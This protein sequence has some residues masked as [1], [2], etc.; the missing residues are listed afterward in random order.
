MARRQ[1]RGGGQTARCVIR[2]ADGTSPIGRPGGGL[3]FMKSVSP[4]TPT[5]ITIHKRITSNAGSHSNTV[6]LETNQI[7]SICLVSTHHIIVSHTWVCCEGYRGISGSSCECDWDRSGLLRY[8]GEYKHCRYGSSGDSDN[9]N[10]A[11]TR[12][13]GYGRIG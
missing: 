5:F 2:A 4:S 8:T 13:C 11:I 12:R 6:R 9:D 3:S 7:Y 10:A 1:V